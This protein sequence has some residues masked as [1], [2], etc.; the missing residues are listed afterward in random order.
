ML[1]YARN[2]QLQGLFESENRLWP[3]EFVPPQCGITVYICS[4]NTS[5]WGKILIAFETIVYRDARC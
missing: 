4:N 2:E 3:I 1:F 5:L